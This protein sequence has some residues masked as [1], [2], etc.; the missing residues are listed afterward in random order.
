[1]KRS[2]KRSGVGIIPDIAVFGMPKYE[3]FLFEQD[4][5]AGMA[6]WRKGMYLP[7]D[8]GA[9]RFSVG[10]TMHRRGGGPKR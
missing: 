10:L 9:W 2:G 6:G 1:M 7:R 5:D 4:T 8:V 3:V